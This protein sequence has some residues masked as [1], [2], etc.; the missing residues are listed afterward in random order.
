MEVEM[1]ETPETTI[2]IR[3]KVVVQE[4]GRVEIVSPQLQPGETAEVIVLVP[5]QV[6]R[7]KQMGALRELFQAT[8]ALPQVHRIT[9]KEISAEIDA[10]RTGR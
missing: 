1:Y 5:K 10:Y 7:D 4:G 2:A 9:E 6:Q 3:Q 8:Q